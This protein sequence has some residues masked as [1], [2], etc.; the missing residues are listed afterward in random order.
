MRA[1]GVD[2]PVGCEGAGGRGPG[3][4]GVAAGTLLTP[5]Q[6]GHDKTVPARSS[7]SLSRWLQWEQIRSIAMSLSLLQS[8]MR[9]DD[10]M[11]FVICH[12]EAVL[13]G[14]NPV[15]SWQWP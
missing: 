11:R 6:V 15:R 1:A 3:A 12:R 9:S 7:C 14:P 10:S 4:V 13:I 8:Y 2:G 5:P